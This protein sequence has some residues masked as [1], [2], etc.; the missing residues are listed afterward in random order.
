MKKALLFF[1]LLTSI[2]LTAQNDPVLIIDN[3][4]ITIKPGVSLPYW[5]KAGQTVNLGTNSKSASILEFTVDSNNLVFSQAISLTVAQ[6]VPSN[7]VWKIEGIGVNTQNSFIPSSN[8]LTSSD[9][10]SSSTSNLPS[11]YQ[12]PKKYDV[13]GTYIWIVPPGI[14]SIC[15]EVWGAGGGGACGEIAIVGGGGGGGYSYQCFTVI[16]GNNYVVTVGAGGSGNNCIPSFREGRAGGDSSLGSLI[17]ATGGRG[18]SSAVQATGGTGNY[19]NGGDAIG[20]NG[21]YGGNGGYGVNGGVNGNFPGGGGGAGF[22]TN[23][24]GSNGAGGQVI[25]YW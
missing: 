1:I 13:P 8:G 17:N 5:L 12:S 9:S 7:K 4:N 6:T 11:I 23:Y 24:G 15:V 21:G 14:T 20:R 3:M 25:I 19:I 16:P 18:G 2:T 22:S 10:T